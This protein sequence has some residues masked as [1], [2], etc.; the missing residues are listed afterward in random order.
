MLEDVY[1]IPS[2]DMK[3]DLFKRDI[4][5]RLELLV[6]ARIPIVTLHALMMTYVD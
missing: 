1:F 6:L 5:L 4:S 3:H 2:L